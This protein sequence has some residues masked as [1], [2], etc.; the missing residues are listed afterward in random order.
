[1]RCFVSEQRPREAWLAAE[2]LGESMENRL[3]NKTGAGFHCLMAAAAV[4]LSMAC[5]GGKGAFWRC[6]LSWAVLT[7]ENVL[8]WWCCWYLAK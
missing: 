7:G 4:G 2:C 5:S 8:G 1:M 6:W 3:R